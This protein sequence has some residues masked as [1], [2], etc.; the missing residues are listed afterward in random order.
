MKFE[1]IINTIQL[2]DSQELLPH[3]LE[4]LDRNKVILVS[5]PPFNVGYHYNSYKDN[6]DEDE[7]FEVLESIFGEDKC[8]L[9][10]YPEQ[11]Y[12][13]SFQ[14]GKFPNKVISWVYNSN[15]AKQHRDIAFFGVEPNMEKVRQPYKNLEDKRIVERIENGSEGGRL[16]DWWEINQVKNVSNEKTNHPCQMPI[17]V[18]KNIIG[19]LPN[20]AIIIDPF[21]G[22]GTTCLAVKEMNDEQKVNRK[23]IGIEIDPEY[24]KIAV[25]RLNGINARGQTSIFTDFDSIGSDKE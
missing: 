8:V 22:S 21:A 11:L 18:M 6:L 5:D 16:Y 10:H 19:I 25:D 12:K 2:G 1:D 7:Y 4:K 9:I 14:I 17:Q 13:F 20:D 24:H 3:I 23:F 15:T